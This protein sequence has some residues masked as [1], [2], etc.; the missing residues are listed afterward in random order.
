MNLSPDLSPD[1]ARL[2]R[3]L[4]SLIELPVEDQAA[5]GRLTLDVRDVAENVDITSEG[6]RPTSC[7]LLLEG[8]ACRY[9]LLQDGQRQIMSFHMSGDL[10]DLQSL[11]VKTMDHGI[12]ALTPCRVGFIPHGELLELTRTQPRIT[13]ALWKDT[14]VDAA[15]FR[16]WLKG[17]GRKT[18]K[19]RIAHL[20]CEVFAR[21][22]AVD[23]AEDDHGFEL[24][25]T[26]AEL[27]DA[28]GLSTVH[29]NR[30]LQ[31]L[32]RDGLIAS[33]GKYWEIRNGPGLAAVAEFDPTYLHLRRPLPRWA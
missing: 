16:L 1:H 29:V 23:L 8:Y 26:Q 5:L 27:G 17:M 11:H 28:L 12:G 9:S 25:V 19:S 32:R 24:P 33:H 31:E 7:C 2:V 10:P 15:I 30:V 3:K 18:A 14:L 21:A 4:D 13:A 6:D 20:L 22:R